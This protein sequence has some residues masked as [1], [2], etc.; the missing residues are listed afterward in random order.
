MHNLSYIHEYPSYLLSF[1]DQKTTSWS[2]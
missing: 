2:K 1:E